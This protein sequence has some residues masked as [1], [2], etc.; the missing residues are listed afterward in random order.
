MTRR[1]HRLPDA[2]RLPR[3]L[4]FQRIYHGVHDWCLQA[5]GASASDPLQMSALRAILRVAGKGEAKVAAVFGIT[6]ESCHRA[7]VHL[8]AGAPDVPVC[9]FAL[10]QPSPETLALCKLVLVRPGSLRLAFD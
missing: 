9:L 7:V 8:R 3:A 5:S 2:P 4:Q 10:S 1:F 6:S